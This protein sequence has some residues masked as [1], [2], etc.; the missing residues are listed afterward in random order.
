M[1]PAGTSAAFA[2][3]FNVAGERAEGAVGFSD[4]IE[5]PHAAAITAA[6]T[7]SIHF[8]R[9][10]MTSPGEP[11]KGMRLT[12]ELGCKRYSNVLTA[13]NGLSRISAFQNGP[14]V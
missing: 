8:I 5:S 13:Q 12:E 1:E 10:C 2:S 6:T 7:T 14:N 3:T 9:V 11:G 4:D